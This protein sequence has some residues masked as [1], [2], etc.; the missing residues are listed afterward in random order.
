MATDACLPVDTACRWFYNRVMI[1]P[2]RVTLSDEDTITRSGPAR[3]RERLSLELSVADAAAPESP[4]C[5]TV[6]PSDRDA[7]ARLMLD[8]YRGTVDYNGETLG[9]ALKEVGSTLSGSYGRFLFDCSFVVDGGTELSSA[10]LVTS[11]NSGESGERALLAFVMT[12]KRHQRQGMAATLV[13][14]SAAALRGKGYTRLE[15]V[16]TTDNAPA[17]QLYARL[18]FRPV[19]AD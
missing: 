16:V 14:H 6:V 2:G 19:Q 5:R 4:A 3:G 17:K 15:L 1:E 8:A 9:D 18:G 12:A 10:S 7:L 13:R 11:F